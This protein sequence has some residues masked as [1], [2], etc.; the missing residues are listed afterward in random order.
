MKHLRKLAV[1]A[2]LT[3]GAVALTACGPTHSHYYVPGHSHVVVH[4]VVTHH[5]VHHVVIK[6]RTRRR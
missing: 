2:G 5:V 6:P 3:V 4:H 1:T